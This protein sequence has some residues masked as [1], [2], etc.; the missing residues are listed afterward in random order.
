VGEADQGTALPCV[1][2]STGEP[3]QR[4]GGDVCQHGGEAV[5]FAEVLNRMARLIGDPLRPA[6]GDDRV[7]DGLRSA[8]RHRPP[9]RMG[10]N[11]EDEPHTSRDRSVERHHAVRREP[12]YHGTGTLTLESVG[13]P[14]GRARSSGAETG[15]GHRLVDPLEE[16]PDGAHQHR[17]DQRVCMAHQWLHQSAVGG[18]VD[19]ESLGSCIDGL[20]DD[21]GLTPAD[22]VAE[23]NLGVH[24]RK[25]VFLEGKVAQ[26]RRG[27]TEGVHGR[28]HV[29]NG[30]RHGQLG[31][32]RTPAQV[33]G[34]LEHGHV[35]A[36]TGQVHGRHEP[37]GSGADDRRGPH[38]TAPSG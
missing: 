15:H 34:G 36:R 22:G 10:E 20:V 31:G 19:A 21:H 35:P 9:H 12:C 32:C 37:V 5:E 11:P 29:G 17:V 13:Q 1:E 33:A 8:L 28:A 2:P 4:R 3:V 27:D 14:P 30:S 23:G 38:P 25:A 6:D 7:R 26:R 18:T 16:R 24:P